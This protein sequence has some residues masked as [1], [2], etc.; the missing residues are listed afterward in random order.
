MPEDQERHYDVALDAGQE[1]QGTGCTIWHPSGEVEPAGQAQPLASG[2]AGVVYRGVTREGMQ[3]AIKLLSPTKELV[4]FIDTE[5][6]RDTFAR[7]IAILSRVTHTRV[8]KILFSGA[9]TVGSER[10]PFYAMEFIEGERLDDVLARGELGGREFLDLVDQVLDGLEYL[11]QRRI[12]HADLKGANVMV[13]RQFGHMDAKILDLGVAKVIHEPDPDNVEAGP[14]EPEPPEYTYFYSSKKIT[15]AEWKPRLGKR[16]TRD[17]LRE[18]FPSHDLFALGMLLDAAL[19]ATP[20]RERLD[21]DLGV[22]ACAALTEIRDRLQ[23]SPGEEHYRAVS[24]LRADWRKLDPRYLSP[25]GVPELALAG[26]ARTS[27]AAPGGRVALTDR[28]LDLI[29]HPLMQRLRNVPQ[30]ELAQLVYPG[31]T[32]TRLL[33]AI[34]AF[35]TTREFIA[36]LLRDPSFRLLVEPPEVEAALISALC[37][38]IGHYP[39]SHMFED[40]SYQEAQGG[41]PRE[42]PS[43]DDLFSVFL[44]PETARNGAFALFVDELEQ[45][46]PRGVKRLDRFLFEDSRFSPEVLEALR[47]IASSATR[48]GQLLRGILDS[49]IDA[50]KVSY[51]ADDSA[52]TGV[53]YGLGMDLDALFGALRAP[54]AEDYPPLGTP[55][56][57]IDD[58]GLP[59]AEQLM[60]ARYWMLRRVYWHHTNRAIMAMVKFV[61][62]LLRQH[63][64]LD[65]RDYFGSTLF[66]GP[67]EGIAYLS[68]ALSAAAKEGLFAAAPVNPLDGVADGGRNLYKR[69]LTVARGDAG[70]SGAIFNRMAARDGAGL[71]AAADAV[72]AELSP[73]IGR[74][75][76]PGEVVIDVPLKERSRTDTQAL[77]YLRRDVRH[78][79]S[80]EEASPVVGQLLNEFDTHVR[81]ARL[82]VSGS[83]AQDLRRTGIDSA[84]TRALAVLS[85]V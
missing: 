38:D 35:G 10:I 50:D 15:R 20:L 51:L 6:F 83:L 72:A 41:K 67:L 45:R 78:P 53:G 58:K 17:E 47:T 31:A 79:K 61:I 33:H 69:V 63:N 37:H 11:H 25:L 9:A 73:V 13:R 65:L 24:Q 60:L 64:A 36:H 4:E 30:L 43:D 5:V 1:L 76:R 18:M 49:P 34:S 14:D 52:M 29:N 28:M 70:P 40:W 85:Q 39:L 12:M 23:L 22:A 2:G 16:I 75:I 48:S 68:D 21:A 80:L 27:I 56:I 3:V 44:D 19:T 81:K 82:Y 46:L 71:L 55:V 54:R 32:H 77:V 74:A 7:E 84:R 26:Q 57:A 8:A 62:A 66:H 59:A 42:I